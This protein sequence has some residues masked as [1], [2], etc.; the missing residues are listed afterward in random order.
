MRKPGGM[1]LLELQD[2]ERK[3]RF[4]ELSMQ[5]QYQVQKDQGYLGLDSD[6]VQNNPLQ[7]IGEVSYPRYNFDDRFTDLEVKKFSEIFNYLD[8]DGNN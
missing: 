1:G 7:N 3:G 2:Q 6:K 4:N 5:P 8:R